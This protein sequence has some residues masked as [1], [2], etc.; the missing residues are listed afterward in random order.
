MTEPA[1]A[2]EDQPQPSVPGGD[3][4]VAALDAEPA[5]AA[6]EQLAAPEVLR[7]LAWPI[8]SE[9]PVLLIAGAMFG[10]VVWFAA[11]KI[12]PQLEWPEPPSYPYCSAER[13]DGP[14]V[15]WRPRKLSRAE[16]AEQGLISQSDGRR[17]VRANTKLSELAMSGLDPV[18][19]ERALREEAETRR[20][21]LAP[22][23]GDVSQAG[24]ARLLTTLILLAVTVLLAPLL[25]LPTVLRLRAGGAPRLMIA[26]YTA[27][28]CLLLTMTVLLLGVTFTAMRVGI[29]MLTSRANPH[30]MLVTATFTELGRH[31]P[32]I[33][34]L[35]S[36]LGRY[37]LVQMALDRPLDGM[38][39]NAA[40]L[41][42]DLRALRELAHSVEWLKS[43]FDIL[44]NVLAVF[45]ALL[46]LWSVRHALLAMARLGWDVGVAGDARVGVRIIR[47]VTVR[48]VWEAVL[49]VGLL[50]I[51]L[52][53]ISA[54]SPLLQWMLEAGTAC[55]IELLLLSLRC[56]VAGPTSVWLIY[57]GLIGTLCFIGGGLAIG[58]AAAMTYAGKVHQAL[59]LYTVHRVPL[60]ELWGFLWR[61][62]LA[63]AWLHALP[64][65]VALAARP[66]CVWLTAPPPP[67]AS[68][69]AAPL[70]QVSAALLGGLGLAFYLGRGVKAQTYL[71]LHQLPVPADLTEAAAVGSGK[72]LLRLA[73]IVLLIV[74]ALGAA[75][76]AACEI[77][78]SREDL[79]Y[80]LTM[81]EL[82][83]EGLGPIDVETEPLP[84]PIAAFEYPDTCINGALDAALR[85]EQA[86]KC[87][88][89]SHELQIAAVL[90]KLA[91]LDALIDG[92][93]PGSLRSS[94]EQV[95]RLRAVAMGLGTRARLA[96]RGE[97]PGEAWDDLERVAR[98]AGALE[99]T[100]LLTHAI[101]GALARDLGALVELTL[102]RAPIEPARARRLA[103]DLEALTPSTLA[104]AMRLDIGW[105]LTMLEQI[106]DAPGELEHP[107]VGQLPGPAGRAFVSQERAGW[108]ANIA[109]GV[110]Q[111]LAIDGAT[112]RA[113]LVAALERGR[114]PVVATWNTPVFSHP[115]VYHRY[116]VSNLELRARAR[117]AQAALLR[118]ADP[119]APLPA[120]PFAPE[121]ALRAAAGQVRSVGPD[122]EPGTEDDL[123]FELRRGE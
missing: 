92:L 93:A 32:Q 59:R 31:A 94:D 5:A 65:G 99:A 119:R 98:L 122:G 103:A 96:L 46:F 107:L 29:E 4:P 56:L 82:V 63:V 90:E 26:K 61:G 16:A 14:V 85:G 70:W 73:I 113:E 22:T 30:K 100:S 38:L 112:S 48:I 97:R 108:A 78:I 69:S 72:L 17:L 54:S 101:R 34:K 87:G 106:E 12:V 62:G 28:S 110:E 21:E 42:G 77:H 55:L 53:L 3:A 117:L 6:P 80:D 114:K 75:A 43:W 33:A 60:R 51:L 52:G 116:F 74:L 11:V 88:H 86:P 104:R 71:A 23:F 84:P 111:A 58:L 67:G 91:P 49:A 66:L 45:I 8:W 7:Q 1:P 35:G 50:L 44:P 95:G 13:P 15:S 109:S 121:R 9:L 2:S 24:E 57:I 36:G 81:K 47:A 41:R 40:T 19:M 120:D 68:I 76:W 83:E 102:G 10:G 18:R 64:L 79:R 20:T 115:E 118:R 89:A 123:V 105:A 37:V 25:V 39:A 27:L